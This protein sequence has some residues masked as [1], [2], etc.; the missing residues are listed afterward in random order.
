VDVVGADRCLV[1]ATIVRDGSPRA[2]FNEVLADVA[3]EHR[4]VRIVDWAS[5]VADDPELLASDAVHGTPDG[6]K[7]RAEATAR[8]VDAC[9]A[10]DG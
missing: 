2:G 3:A 9:P 1:W 10:V 8:A 6:Y 7:R 5:F 4:N